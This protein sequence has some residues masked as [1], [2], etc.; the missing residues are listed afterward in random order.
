[1]TAPISDQGF[2]L[3]SVKFGEGDK[4]LK[5]LTINHGLIDLI[6]KGSNRPNSRKSPHIDLLNLIK[7][8]TSRG[9]PPRYL[10][11]VESRQVFPHIKSELSL[12]RAAFY[13][14]ELLVHILPSNEVDY[15]I[16][17]LI[18]QFLNSLESG[19]DLRSTTVKF[20]IDIIN[21]LGFPKPNDESP[22][23]LIYYFEKLLDRNL[24][25]KDFKIG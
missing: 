21:H 11:Q 23:S 13:I 8:Q 15:T 18:N 19:S 22:S 1:M 12:T 9:G 24:K 25:S 10:S 16:F 5:V 14:C 3:H 4:F 2:I 17:N 6:S 7:F 20:Q